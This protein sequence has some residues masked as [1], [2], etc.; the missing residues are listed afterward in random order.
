LSA[1]LGDAGGELGVAVGDGV[2]DRQRVES[3]LDRAEPAE[4]VLVKAFLSSPSA[5][6]AGRVAPLHMPAR[7]SRSEAV[8]GTSRG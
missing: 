7:C 2:V 8:T 3:A 6:E 1:D 5:D 4:S